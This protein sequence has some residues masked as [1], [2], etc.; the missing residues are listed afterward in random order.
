VDKLQ[1]YLT[2]KGADKHTAR[3]QARGAARGYLGNALSTE[4]IFS[5][6]VAQWR[7]ILAQRC[8]PA[9]DAE[10]RVLAARIL[11]VLQASRYGEDFADLTLVETPDV[12]GPYIRQQ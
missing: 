8:H 4:I 7:R 9:A 10:I 6:S 2:T 11:P 3:K 5:A 12:I 1:D